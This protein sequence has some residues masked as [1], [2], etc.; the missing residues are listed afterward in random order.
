MAGV[1]RPRR[2]A[3]IDEAP[4]DWY[5]R[6]G[7]AS[8]AAETH[9]WS[10]ADWARLRNAC[11]VSGLAPRLAHQLGE[12]PPAPELAAFGRW[13]QTCL[14]LNHQRT[15]VLSD[16]LQTVLTACESAG[17][18]AMVLKGCAML[19][20]DGHAP[21]LRPTTDIDLLVRPASQT[22]VRG[23]L[24][25]AGYLLVSSDGRH[26]LYRSPAE[27]RPASVIGEH[28][29]LPLRV[30]VHDQVVLRRAGLL[31]ADLTARLWSGAEP[32]EVLGVPAWRPARSGLFE[33]VLLHFA[34]D[35]VAA[36]S[37]AVQALD[38]ALLAPAM[39][40]DDWTSLAAS[41]ARQGNLPWAWLGLHMARR[42]APIE[43][44]DA[45]E[46]RLTAATPQAFRE[47][48]RTFGWAAASAC[49]P[50]RRIEQLAWPWTWTL[51]Q[52]LRLV[53]HFCQRAPS[54]TWWFVHRGGRPRP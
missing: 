44:P 2:G 15:Q 9:G 17:V 11:Q 8:I 6:A 49:N 5:G 30:E 19:G 1:A 40:P 35:V 26:D 4:A 54:A 41:L 10:L 36:R 28:P 46:H 20:H 48:A 39:Q 24:H 34:G 7:W 33:H 27:R 25:E 43:L 47:R 38:L 3:A 42:L 12:P 13:L 51:R 18:A 45:L 22:T 37:R 23:L 32:G 21:E 31:E 14:R 52:R 53:G 50:Q 16:R 29:L